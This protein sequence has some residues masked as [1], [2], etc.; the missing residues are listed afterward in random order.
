M[1]FFLLLSFVRGSL[2]SFSFR[3][4]RCFSGQPNKWSF[5]INSESFSLQIKLTRFVLHRRKF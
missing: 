4:G 5:E 1:K 3:R 2:G